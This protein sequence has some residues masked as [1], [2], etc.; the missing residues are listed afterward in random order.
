[1][2]KTVRLRLSGRVQGVGYRV[3]AIERARSLGLLGWVRN[4]GDGSVEMLA[5]GSAQAVA[6]LVEACRKGPPAARVDRV[7]F[8]EALDDGSTGFAAHPDL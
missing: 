5:T 7:E 4:R 8:V 1:M 3:W 2:M 6:S